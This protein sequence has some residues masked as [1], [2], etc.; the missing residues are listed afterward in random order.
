MPKW[1]L[2]KYKHVKREQRIYLFSE[3]T[4]WWMQIIKKQNISD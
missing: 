1:L 2:I 3:W 4:G